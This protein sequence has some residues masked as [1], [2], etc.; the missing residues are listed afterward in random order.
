MFLLCNY[1]DSPNELCFI[2]DSTGS[3]KGSYNR[4]ITT[5]NIIIHCLIL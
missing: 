4:N 5:Q 3:E 1:N 2:M